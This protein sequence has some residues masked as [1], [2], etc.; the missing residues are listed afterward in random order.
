MSY[1]YFRKLVWFF[2]ISFVLMVLAG[3]FG[4]KPHLAPV[5]NA[6]FQPSAKNTYLVRRGDTIYSIAWAFGVDYRALATLNHLRTPYTIVA[7]Q[8]L[9]MTTIPRGQSVKYTYTAPTKRYVKSSTTRKL[10]RAEKPGYSGPVS[11]GRW[12]WPTK[13]RLVERF[14]PGIVSSQGIA[15]AGKYG[16]PILASAKGKVVYSGDGVRGYGNLVIIKHNRHYLSA[17]AFN[18]RNLVK[19]GQIVRSG[20]VIAR[21]GK[22]NAGRTLLYFEIRRDGRPVNPLRFLQ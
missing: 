2:L 3:C 14:T 21:M 6:W 15:I 16:Q 7:G 8:R 5:V 11:I 1:K 17:Y 4:G 20:S 18:Q 22:N 12:H 10:T 9:R 19:V 13:G